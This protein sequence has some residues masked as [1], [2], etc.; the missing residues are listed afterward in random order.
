M[1]ALNQHPGWLY[2]IA[3]LLP[4]A[5]FVFLLLFGA[6]RNVARA[7]RATGPGGLVYGALGGDTPPR[8][9]AYVATAAIGLSCVLSL[10]GLVW[11]LNTHRNGWEVHLRQWRDWQKIISNSTEQQHARRKQGCSNWPA[12]EWLGNIHTVLPAMPNE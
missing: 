7:Y 4:L 2:V 8:I 10:V 6:V 9:G 11:F 1:D 12:N 3:T 5:S